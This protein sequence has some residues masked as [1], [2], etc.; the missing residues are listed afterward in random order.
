MPQL[1]AISDLHIDYAQNQATLDSLQAYPD[2]H[3]LVAGDISH[4]IDLF[5]YCMQL[6]SQKFAQV[7]WCPGNH[8]LWEDS[9]AQLAGLAKYQALIRVCDSYGIHHPEGPYVQLQLNGK[10]CHI[11]PTF[12]GY[13]YSFSPYPSDPASALAW[14][15]EERHVSADESRLKTQPFESMRHWCQHR[16]DYTAT[17]LAACEDSILYLNHY[18]ILA[19]HAVLPLIPRFSVWCGTHLSEIFLERFPIE[20]VVYGHL[21]I[22][23]S[24]T[25]NGVHFHE[26][27][28][29]YP[30]QQ[31]WYGSDL[32]R[33]LVKIGIIDALY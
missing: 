27:S 29:G 21:H 13:D 14:A 5:E 18:P 9:A 25:E 20:T 28:F 6:L 10:A 23:R 12:T 8:D 19:E 4:R 17:R 31:L 11:C 3:L 33:R 26:T 7:Y 30:K 32:N 22:P 16:I 24:F 2:D 15:Q 1:Y